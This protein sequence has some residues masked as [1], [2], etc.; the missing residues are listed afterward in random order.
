MK[1]LI[2]A[3]VL[4]YECSSVAEPKEAK[5]TEEA[6]PLKSFDFVKEVF[7]GRVRDI[8][9][10]TKSDEYTLYI[11]GKGNFR[12]DIAVSQPYKGK[13]DEKKPYHYDNL[14]AYILSHENAVLVEGMEADD[15]M[16][17][18]QELKW[19]CGEGD[20]YDLDPRFCT[21]V[22]C[23]RDKDLRIVPGWHYGWECGR[24]PEFRMQFIDKLGWLTLSGDRKSVK[25]GGLKFFWSQMLTGDKTDNIPGL[26][27]TGPVAAYEALHRCT[28]EGE[29][30]L[31]VKAMY[32]M[33]HPDDWREYML[34][35]GRL[36]WMVQCL[37]DE[38]K[39]VMW[40]I[41]DAFDG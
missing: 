18:A 26:H 29:L 1:A 32:E 7:D 5:G 24:Q 40:E 31:T 12:F 16:A 21:T 37:D 22:I 41:P 38:G 36:L 10:A 17:I 3:D 6:Q 2:D 14:K 25:G 20:V 13:R 11:T 33:E 30:Y 27:G 19:S 28:T 39:P 9:E 8:L 34:E 4:L 15:A 23:T 35:Q